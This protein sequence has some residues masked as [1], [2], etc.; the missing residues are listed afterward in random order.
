MT[1]H[2]NV[3]SGMDLDG[4]VNDLTLAVGD[5]MSKT[6]EGVHT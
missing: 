5:A 3:N 6:A 1:N 2:N 4:I